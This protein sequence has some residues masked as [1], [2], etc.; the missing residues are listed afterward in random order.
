MA[1]K[2]REQ[3]TIHERWAQDSGVAFYDPKKKKWVV[4]SDGPDN[5]EEVAPQPKKE[6]DDIEEV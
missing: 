5:G 2:E 6:I 1:D 4:A 3:R